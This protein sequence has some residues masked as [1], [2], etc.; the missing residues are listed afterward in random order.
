MATLNIIFFY[1]YYFGDDVILYF[2]HSHLEGQEFWMLDSGRM[3][4]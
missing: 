4:K 3:C 1:Y 2:Q